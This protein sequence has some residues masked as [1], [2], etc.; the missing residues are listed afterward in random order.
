M[1][2]FIELPHGGKGAGFYVSQ[3]IA[4]L[5]STGRDYIIQGQQHCTLD[6]HTKKK[7][8]SL[9]VWLRQNFTNRGDVAQAVNKVIED[10]VL[11]GLFTEGKF[12][13][14]DSGKPCKGIKSVIEKAEAVAANYGPPLVLAS[15]ADVEARRMAGP[16]GW[17][18][19]D[20]NR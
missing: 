5:R 8:Q 4:H 2:T 20:P 1:D 13:C 15:S 3:L 14:P 16:V 12:T 18:D 6:K 9:D 19:D 10:L 7:S 11:T 17:C